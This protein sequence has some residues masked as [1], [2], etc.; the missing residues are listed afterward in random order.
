MSIDF[1][2]KKVFTREEL[3]KKLGLDDKKKNVV[4]M[5]HTFT[6][7]VFN[8][9]NYYYRDYYDWTEKTLKIASKVKDVNWILKPHPTRAAYNES[10]DSIENMFKKYN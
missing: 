4:I 10:K 6:D 1:T 7:A 5:A 8:Y 2:G 3:Q 9:G